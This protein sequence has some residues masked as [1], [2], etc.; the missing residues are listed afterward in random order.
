MFQNSYRN[1]QAFFFL[2]RKEQGAR[3]IGTSCQ[4]LLLTSDQNLLNKMAEA[5]QTEVTK[6]RKSM[7]E[8]SDKKK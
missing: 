5:A 4:I 6:Y 1:I 8:K 7:K 2:W 3:K